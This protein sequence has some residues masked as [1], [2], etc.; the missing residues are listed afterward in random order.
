M[1]CASSGKPPKPG[2]N[3]C[4]KHLNQPV[5]GASGRALA[6]ERVCSDGSQSRGYAG[7]RVLADSQARGWR[8]FTFG[9]GDGLRPGDGLGLSAG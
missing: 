2:A 3:A 8:Y 1:R 6:L 5:S 4:L 7:P 9:D